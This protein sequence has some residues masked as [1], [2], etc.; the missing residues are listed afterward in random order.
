VDN[1]LP[2]PALKTYV[3]YINMNEPH[4]VAK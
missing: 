3:Q 2:A 1:L 4:T